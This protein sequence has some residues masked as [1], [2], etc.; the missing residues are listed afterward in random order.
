MEPKYIPQ[1]LNLFN[2]FL[3]KA[4]LKKFRN[5]TNYIIK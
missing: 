1:V 5:F 4:P 3:I 2:N